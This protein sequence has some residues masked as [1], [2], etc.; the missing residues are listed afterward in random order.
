M[1]SNP[2][3]RTGSPDEAAKKRREERDEGSK[4]RGRQ[5]EDDADRH[6]GKHLNQNYSVAALRLRCGKH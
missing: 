3:F 6:A 1:H 4:S 2:K 5:E